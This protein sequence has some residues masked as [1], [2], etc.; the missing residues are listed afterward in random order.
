MPIIVVLPVLPAAALAPPVRMGHDYSRDDGPDEGL[1]VGSATRPDPATRPATRLAT[2]P[3]TDPT[4][5]PPVSVPFPGF[6]S[7]STPA[8]TPMD[9]M[10]QIFP[11]EGEMATLCRR[12]DWASTP[13]GPAESWPMS[14]RTIVAT[15]LASRHPMIL[16]W[17][18]E[19][20][21]IY[22]DAYRPSLGRGARHPEAL[23]ARAREF[24]PDAWSTIEPQ[25]EQV[26]RGGE[27]TW[28][29]DQ[30]VPIFRDGRMEDVYWTYGYSSVRDDE[31]RIAGVLAVC[32]ET[33]D[34]V[35]R[36]GE[37]AERERRFRELAESM[38]QIVWTADA[39]GLV[40]YQTDSVLKL[41]GRT[42]DELRGERWLEVLHPDDVESTVRAWT[43]AVSSGTPYVSRFR[44]R[45][46]DGTYR[47]HLTRGM[48]SHD[49]DGRI[50]RWYGSSTDIHEQ[51]RT[52]EHLREQAE[53]LDRAQDA[54]LVRDLE[55]RVLYWNAGAERLFGWSADEVI[56]RRVPEALYPD[57][58][59]FRSAMDVLLEKG[60]WS[61]ELEQVRRD[62]SRIVVE[63]RWSL[64][65][66]AAGEPVRVLAIDT[67]VTERRRLLEQF[68]RAQRMES[69]GTLAG[70]IAH[71]LNNV[72]APILLSIDL[73]KEE[74]RDP[75]GL[76]TL[77]TIEGSARRGADMVKQ[78]LGFARGVEGE[79]VPVDLRSVLADLGRVVRDT[80]PRSITLRVDMPDDLRPLLGDPTQVQQVLLNL[81]VNARDA[82]PDGG[83]LRVEAE[84]VDLDEQYASMSEN[85][86]PGPHVR[87]SVIDTGTGMPPRVV[88]RI[89]DPFFTTKDVGEG[90]GL[91]LSTVA[92]IV[93]SHGGFVNV[94]S[95]R[96]RG[97][98][99]RLHF[100]AGDSIADPNLRE[101]LE[102]SPDP[103][104][105]RA[106]LPGG[107]GELV[108]LID[109]EESVR[110]ITARTLEAHGYR[111]V[112]AT[113]GAD[114]VGV[115]GQR[116][117]EI[118]LVLTDITMPIMDGPTTIR[119]LKR[120]NPE[121]RII[122]ASGLG[123]NGGVVR[124]ADLGVRHFL[125]K[126]Y[127]A[128]ALLQMVHRA[129]REE[130]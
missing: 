80:F 41:T 31:G 89:F 112:T 106:P 83:V 90:T 56:G 115:Y 108:L 68:L 34:R 102:S 12:F 72:L 21:Q 59:P 49:S 52:E 70:G 53:L 110:T 94:Y 88:E 120:M 109:D 107:N 27:A 114:A 125:P 126:P 118:A 1:G 25:I 130:V 84:N 10:T 63:A 28:H 99:F 82:M 32:Q 79:R 35:R 73:L 96:G 42:R 14:L 30:L 24:W 67:D 66:D 45:A 87:L 40:D 129:L 17:G 113:D 48:P 36:A 81:F 93:Q 37:I 43:E 2:H 8:R 11:G 128:D 119:A 103:A 86:S 15:M 38:P 98:T 116:G 6:A 23:G 92:A 61:G 33:T 78:V 104:P 22:N 97:S 3:A 122:A 111:V 50:V 124:A 69:I 127:T 117:G 100:P 105:S 91:G 58:G 64:I 76:E 51:I 101:A 19:S 20:V 55:H 26:M 75:A 39:D 47:W 123:A 18:P 13:I 9:P 74:I 95:E 54:I 7:S 65:R 62:G 60:E 16:F 5:T 85:A 77:T 57:P 29:E 4:V 121:V 46:A 44:I 71:D